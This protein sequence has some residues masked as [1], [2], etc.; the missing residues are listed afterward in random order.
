MQANCAWTEGKM[1][2]VL[3]NQGHTSD[4]PQGVEGIRGG[5]PTKHE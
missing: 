1:I 2:Q 3:P 5:Y 4:G